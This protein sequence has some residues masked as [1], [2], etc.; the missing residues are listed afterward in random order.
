MTSLPTETLDHWFDETEIVT[1]SLNYA[2]FDRSGVLYQRGIGEFQLDGRAP[3]AETVYRIASMSKSFE[4]AAALVLVERGLLSLDDRV[5]KWVPEF[6]DPVDAA[7]V[8]LPVT[9]RMV[10]SNA[11]GL[12]EDNGWADYELALSRQD[13]LAEVDAGLV[14]AGQPGA[15]FQ[16]SNIG[17]W[18]LGVVVENVAGM[19]FEE[20]AHTSLLEPLGLT[21]TRYNASEYV[22]SE[23]AHGFGTFD[24]GET[25]FDRPFVGTGIGGC[26]AS[27]FSTVGDI[28]AW[29]AWLSSAFD[30]GNTDDAVLTRA[31]RRMMQSIHTP[32]PAGADRPL[33]QSIE[34]SGY[35][36]GLVIE[37]D[38]RFGPIVQHSGGLPGWSSN[39][40]WHAA[41]GIGIVV[42]ANTNGVRPGI[43]ATGML[44]AVLSAN[45]TPARTIPLWPSTVAAASAL[46]E[47]IA[48]GDLTQASAL[49]SPNLLSDVPA[50]VRATRL[51]T[52]A[53]EV[54]GLTAS[55]APITERLSWTVSPAHVAWTVPGATGTLE[56]RIEMTP[57]TPAMIQRLEIEV[58][59]PLSEQS[60]V[61]RHY[62]PVV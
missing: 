1:P 26:A 6:R 44:R 8:E 18:L 56:C 46:D 5:S 9:V 43:A 3:T 51:E 33:E 15:G 47:A 52:A 22:L 53:S 45:E 7:G 28:A 59:K 58:Q 60:P 4:I 57:T 35:G 62:L 48:N 42:F 55:T 17:F 20:F 32:A 39:M 24:K 41:S 19:P 31:S 11:S 10:M 38:V 54:G 29:S 37:H 16:Y 21:D 14:F 23:I 34:G 25:W 49:F 2:V 36:L 12:P 61:M 30:E 40:R 13:F 50:D 27:M